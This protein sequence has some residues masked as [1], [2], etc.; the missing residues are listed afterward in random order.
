MRDFPS[1]SANESSRVMSILDTATEVPSRLPATAL[2]FVQDAP[3]LCSEWLRS[4]HGALQFSSF[5]KSCRVLNSHPVSIL[6]LSKS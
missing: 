6:L 1:V 3:Y 2:D 5:V 4:L